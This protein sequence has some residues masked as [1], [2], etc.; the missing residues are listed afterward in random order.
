M[1]TIYN[2]LEKILP[3]S[4]VSYDFMKN[5]FIAIILITPLLGMV[6]TLIVQKK[7]AFFSDALGHSALTGLAIGVVLGVSDTNISMIVFAVLF[8]LLL[9]KIKS[10][11]G[12]ESDTI[13][14][15]FASCSIAIGLIVLSYQGNFNNYSSLLIGDILSITPGE[16]KA[17]LVVFI[18]TFILW[19][20]L[21]NKMLFVS[22]NSSLAR[23]KGIKV[24]LI[25]NIF[26]VLIAVI[27]MLAIKWIGILLINALM[28]LPVAAAK[29]I[30]TNVRQYHL[31]SV[32]FSLFSGI[33]GLLV[34]YYMNVACGPVIIVYASILFFFSYIVKILQK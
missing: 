22:L 26:V 29:N 34:S 25:E 5:A 18:I 8:A 19:W 32:I 7:M 11:Q 28:I 14:S 13:I 12:I 17:L 9:N 30:S 16:I 23:S 10:K 15:V 1:E 6:G 27:V 21:Y 4:W 33:C 31:F 3:F 2:I 20:G 24:N